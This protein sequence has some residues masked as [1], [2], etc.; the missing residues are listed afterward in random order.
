M[1]EPAGRAIALATRPTVP[2]TAFPAIALA[3]RPTIPDTIPCARWRIPRAAIPWAGSA[4]DSPS[5]LNLFAGLTLGRALDAETQTL[6]LDYVGDGPPNDAA[7]RQRLQDAVA[8]M[9]ASPAFQ[10]T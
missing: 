2:S 3:A 8:L 5:I 9:I 4:A 1:A 6:L 7:A 10:W